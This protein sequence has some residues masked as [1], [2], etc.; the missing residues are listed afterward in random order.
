[1][2]HRSVRMYHL[3]RSSQPIASSNVTPFNLPVNSYSTGQIIE[4]IK[5]IYFFEI[6]N[7]LIPTTN[8][9]IFAEN[10]EN[11]SVISGR[12]MQ[13]IEKYEPQYSGPELALF[14]RSGNIDQLSDALATEADEGLGGYKPRRSAALAE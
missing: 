13:N 9:A 4:I 11:S 5:N 12:L 14:C 7:L 2:A 10:P 3:V 8:V 6:E 1:M